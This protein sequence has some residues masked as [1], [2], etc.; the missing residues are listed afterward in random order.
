MSETI[1]QRRTDVR[2]LMVLAAHARARKAGVPC[3]IIHSDIVIPSHC[4]VLGLP[5]YRQLGKQGGGPNSPSLDRITPELGYIPGNI[6]VIS[7]RANRI[8]S[9]A[10]PEE[11]Q[12]L[13]DFYS[14]GIRSVVPRNGK[15]ARVR[16]DPS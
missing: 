1:G 13:A 12:A 4:P 6:I 16:K 8:K 7:S 11:M 10:T 15:K 9:D 5:L 2:K 14:F 3:T